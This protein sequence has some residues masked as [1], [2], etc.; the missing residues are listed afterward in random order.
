MTR[1]RL[2]YSER[3]PPC[4]RLSRLVVALSGG[5]LRRVAMES[6]EAA[7]LYAVHP[8]WFGRLVLE[9]EDGFTVGPA[10]YG[11]VARLVATA[12]LP[13]VLRKKR[14]EPTL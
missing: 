12:L 7:P 6:P 13:P 14:H 8:H 3:C 5:R 11:K 9:H 1:A 2:F 10:V 4:R